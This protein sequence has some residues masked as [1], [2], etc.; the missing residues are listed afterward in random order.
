MWLSIIYRKSN[1]WSDPQNVNSRRQFSFVSR[2]SKSDE[3][4]VIMPNVFNLNQPVPVPIKNKK[5]AKVWQILLEPDDDEDEA[6]QEDAKLA[7]LR[8][9]MCKLMPD[10]W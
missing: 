5:V 9:V 1:S 7:A 3:H 6:T 2:A 10:Q 8:E 4:T